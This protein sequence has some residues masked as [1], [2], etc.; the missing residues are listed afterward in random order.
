MDNAEN[1][2]LTEWRMRIRDATTP[3]ELLRIAEELRARSEAAQRALLAENRSA[4][5]ELCGSADKPSAMSR[6]AEKDRAG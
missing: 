6:A 5:S 2:P 1:Q 3:G 4:E